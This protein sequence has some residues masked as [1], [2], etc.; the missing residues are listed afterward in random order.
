MG[1]HATDVPAG[2]VD[3]NHTPAVGGR[4]AKAHGVSVKHGFDALSGLGS[5]DIGMTRFTHLAFRTCA[6]STPAPS[7]W[8]PSSSGFAA[9]AMPLHPVV[10]AHRVSQEP[11]DSTQRDL[12]KPLNAWLQSAQ[13]D[14]RQYPWPTRANV[15]ACQSTQEDPTNPHQHSAPLAIDSTHGLLNSAVDAI[16]KTS[17]VC[18]H[19]C[20]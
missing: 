19:L 9:K 11:S 16:A 8:L 4:W 3:V 18:G 14:S 13:S 2:R 1:R 15:P 7:T 12:C 6:Q 20:V 10:D 5:K 17:G